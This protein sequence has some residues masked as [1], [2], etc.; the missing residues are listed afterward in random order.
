MIEGSKGDNQVI[1]IGVFK[2]NV[3]Y[4]EGLLKFTPAE[5]AAG[6]LG[7]STMHI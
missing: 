5:S 6:K 3:A 2:D 7:V 4:A 1:C